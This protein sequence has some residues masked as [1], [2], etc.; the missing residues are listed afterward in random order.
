MSFDDLEKPIEKPCFS[1]GT[2]GISPLPFVKMASFQPVSD[3]G[4]RFLT[5]I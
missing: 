1:P 2:V 4:L 5:L 3:A